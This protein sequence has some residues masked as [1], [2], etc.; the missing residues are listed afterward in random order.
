MNVKDNG[1]HNLGMNIFVVERELLIDLINTA[2]VRGLRYW[3]RDVLLNQLDTL[4][5][6]GYKFE[7]MWLVSQI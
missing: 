7:D 4:K 6:C 5:V 3:E 1:V 2:F